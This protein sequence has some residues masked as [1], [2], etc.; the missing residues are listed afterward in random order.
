MVKLHPCCRRRTC[1]R[2]VLLLRHCPDPCVYKQIP[3]PRALS[4]HALY[5]AAC[6]SAEI[7]GREV[8]Q[9]LVMPTYISPHSSNTA[10]GVHTRIRPPTSTV[11]LPANYCSTRMRRPPCRSRAPSTRW[12]SSQPQPG[13]R[14]RCSTT[15]PHRE[16][17]SSIETSEPFSFFC[18]CRHCCV[19]QQAASLFRARTSSTSR[20]EAGV[21]GPGVLRESKGLWLRS[22]RGD[23][24]Q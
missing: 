5:T 6:C 19:A 4:S 7:Q 18:A 10:R 2:L 9:R 15:Q 21:Q 24:E 22:T 17:S 3:K 1:L 11:E 14:R 23:D 13:T 16:N 12:D 20:R 8:N